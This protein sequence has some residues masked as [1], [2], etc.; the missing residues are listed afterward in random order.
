MRI[1]AAS[2]D[3]NKIDKSRIVEG[4]NGALYYNLTIMC[5]DSKDK[6]DN[7]VSVQQGQTK[8]E[9]EAKAKAVYLGNGKTVYDNTN[10]TKKEPTGTP[11]IDDLPF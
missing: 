8:E 6:Y 10:T 3:L 2:I 4:K 1:I 7:D 5:N 11:A 9:R